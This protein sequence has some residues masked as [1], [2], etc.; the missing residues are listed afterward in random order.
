MP[1]PNRNP[2]TYGRTFDLFGRYAPAS[3]V[4]LD[5]PEVSDLAF[6][7]F[8][9]LARKTVFTPWRKE[10]Y[11]D[12][13]Y[14]ELGAAIGR[15]RQ[16]ALRAIKLLEAR[17]YV[18]VDDRNRGGIRVR[19]TIKQTQ[20][21]LFAFAQGCEYGFAFG[22]RTLDECLK[23]YLQQRAATGVIPNWEK[24]VED[25]TEFQRINPGATAQDYE[26]ARQAQFARLVEREA[27]VAH[28]FE[29]RTHKEYVM[30]DK[31]WEDN[32]KALIRVM[33][34]PVRKVKTVS[35]EILES[36]PRVDAKAKVLSWMT[37]TAER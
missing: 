10:V 13:T 32:R 14:A 8:V 24:L 36:R 34:T 28:E 37:P 12:T 16:S 31:M 1:K 6:R 23:D 4:V 26:Q 2:E 29:E 11:V 27:K 22:G 19:F 21:D 5:D 15:E 17:K 35:R 7:V 18:T 30:S 20:F 33:P 3:L 9:Q 25:V